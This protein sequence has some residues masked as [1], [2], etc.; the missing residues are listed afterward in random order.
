VI[1][2]KYQIIGTL[3]IIS[4][5]GFFVYNSGDDDKKLVSGIFKNYQT[6]VLNNKG[7]DAAK[8]VS[9]GTI[10]YYS[11]LLPLVKS[12]TPGEIRRLDLLDQMV[13]FLFRGTLTEEQILTSNGRD[14]YIISADKGQV[15]KDAVIR[16]TI[17]NIQINDNFASADLLIDGRK[18]PVQQEFRK[19]NGEW[20]IDLINNIK[21][22][23]VK[24]SYR[25]TM[26]EI[27][28]GI[29]LETDMEAI[30]YILS[31]MIMPDFDLDKIWNTY[32]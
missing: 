14:I 27:K 11:N 3:F 19:E 26:D 18:L 20:K 1:D 32:E 23:L 5:I 2:K 10:Q 6:A 31:N 9:D 7:E 30:E 8:Y 15:N 22:P 12:A 16:Q 13:I 24:E 28:T 29:G 17:K 4:I 21:N 25:N